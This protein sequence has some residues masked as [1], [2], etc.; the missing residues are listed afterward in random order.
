[1]VARTLLL[2]L[3]LGLLALPAHAQPIQIVAFGDSN[4]AGFRVLAKNA[5]P[6]QLERALREKGYDV[7]VFNSGVSGETSGMGL[8]RFD[9]AIPR[10]TN[11]AIVYF[12]RNDVRW[13]IEP[14]KIR[15][16]LDEILKKLRERNIRC[17]LVGLRTLDLSKVAEENGAV[18]Y[19]NFFLGVAHNGEKD[20]KYTLLFDPIQHL[21][22][23]GYAVVVQNLLPYVEA[24]LQPEP[25]QIPLTPAAPPV[26]VV[27][28][29][30]VT[31]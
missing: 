23:K 12:G 8:K 5:Y 7:R 3:V 31:R 6:A 2:T 24:L 29:R 27:P 9:R 14:K 30:T 13:G 11:V 10:D 26:E 25:P 18:Y 16:N 19:P 20:P 1:M 21:N 15:A 22:T 4:T 17:L 28:P